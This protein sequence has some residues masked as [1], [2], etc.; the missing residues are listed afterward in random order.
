MEGQ[1]SAGASMAEAPSA[2]LLDLDNTL[3]PYEPARQAAMKAVRRKAAGDLGLG[4]RRFDRAFAEARAAVKAQ[5]GPVAA[6]HSRLLYFQRM[7]EMLGMKSQP[8]MA[9]DF[10]QTYWRAFL[11][12]MRL[13]AHA[14]GFL[15]AARELGIRLGIVTDLTAQIQFRKLVRLGLD[16]YF[17]T[18][19][20]SEEA[21]ANKPAAAPFLLARERLRLGTEDRVWMVGDDAEA[22]LA[23]AKRHLGARTFLFRPNPAGGG[24]QDGVD[25]TFRNF[26]ELMGLLTGAAGDTGRAA[27]LLEPGPAG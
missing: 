24:T 8:L 27:H 4:A 3:Y 10:E 14:G 26:G 20:T 25:V 23:G 13:H 12:A 21:G 18:V 15:G 2:I 19:V 1:V 9:L 6:S 22:D 11:L 7:L 16:P 17:D 5:L